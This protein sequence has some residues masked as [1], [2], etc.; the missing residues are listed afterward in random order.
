MLGKL[1]KTKT[2]IY[3]F[4]NDVPLHDDDDA[5]KVN[6]CELIIFNEDGK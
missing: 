3:R 5:L 6:W 4:V 2:Y 1:K